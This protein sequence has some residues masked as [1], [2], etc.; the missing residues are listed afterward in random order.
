MQRL[1][2]NSAGV[3]ETDLVDKHGAP[4]DPPGGVT[5]K[6]RDGAGVD[7]VE[8]AAAKPVDAPVGRWAV[9]VEPDDV[10]TLDDY[11]A[12]FEFL[13]G[14][15]ERERVEAFRVV[16]RFYCT[17]A[18]LREFGAN[19]TL[20]SSAEFPDRILRK[21]R[22]LAEE[23][24]EDETDMAFSPQARRLTLTGTG[25]STLLLPIRYPSTLIGGT[26][27][28]EAIT[29][30]DLAFF[31]LR[32]HELLW[33]N[34]LWPRTWGGVRLHVGHGLPAVPEDIREAT[35]HIVRHRVESRSALDERAI[36]RTTAEGTLRLS[37]AGKD[38]PTGLP[39]VDATIERYSGEDDDTALLESVQL[40]TPTTPDYAR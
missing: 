20:A 29:E 33:E 1:E 38:G 30:P 34:D 14:A 12:T 31:H 24:L 40:T 6:F 16:G 23:L 5:V 11:T 21:Y 7:V 15:I 4:F 18:D 8:R 35:M 39:F 10:T 37:T 19:K 9:D 22:T 17:L 27:D 26:I 2:R 3:I 13:E 32:G 25:R 28:G 36:S